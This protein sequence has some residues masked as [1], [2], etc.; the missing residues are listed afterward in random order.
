MGKVVLQSLGICAIRR[1]HLF[2]GEK[3]GDDFN[4]ILVV[5]KLQISPILAI[6]LMQKQAQYWVDSLKWPPGFPRGN[7]ACRHCVG[8]TLCLKKSCR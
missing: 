4:S 3:M 1:S 2:N 5:H 6:A 8:M 7:G